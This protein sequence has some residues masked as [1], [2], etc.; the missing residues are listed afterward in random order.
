MPR[1]LSGVGATR[2]A[3]V[4]AAV[5]HAPGPDVGDPPPD[6]AVDADAE[7]RRFEAAR[8]A[9]R[10][11]IGRERERAAERLDDSEAAVFDAH[12]QFLED[13][14]V[15]EGVAARIDSGLP[16]EHA[17]DGAFAEFIERF[18]GLDGRNAERA[19]DLRDVRD[20]LLR[21]LVG[22]RRGDLA[23][24]PEGSVVLADRLTPSDT[25]RLDPGRVAG[26]ATVA[27][28]RTAHAA[29]FAR[30]LGLPA[31][32]GVG[33]ALREVAAGETVL[34]D[35]AG[36]EVVVDPGPATREAVGGDGEVEIRPGR[37][38]TADGTSVEV[39]ANVG[40]PDDLDAA[41]RHGA[42][43]VGLFR[44]ECLFFDRASPPD[45][46]E[47]YEVYRE[48]LSA[49][50]DGRVVVRT[51]DVGGD[52]PV[53]GDAPEEANPFLGERGIRRSLGPDADVFET[54]LRA[55]LRAAAGSGGR[56][57]VM[58]PMVSTVAEVVEAREV[59]ASVA[60]DLDAAGEAYALP[61]FGV[62]VE[63]PAAAL[64]A[65]EL[66][67]HV[68]FVSLGTNDLAQY[69]MAAARGNPRV[70]GLADPRHPAVL[71]AIHGVVA[72]AAGT[73]VR[74]GICGEMAGD[75][76]LTELLVGLGIRGLSVAPA[77]VPRVKRAVAGVRDEDAQ[78]LAE[79][80]LAADTRAAVEGLLDEPGS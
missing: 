10:G 30:S 51:L 14:Q 13:P 47:Q 70:A 35:G 31:V 38:T 57:A 34:V 61:A 65:E 59:L 52:K 22:E 20:R 73:D 18:E 29:I 68:E 11:A 16:A 17:V 67:D 1:R 36:G 48:A 3:G 62:M 43:G 54:Q 41:A 78:E 58:L 25:A 60:A 2:A 75:P 21:H 56:L 77:S 44:T 79:R 6:G 40:R 64:L 7:A 19:D 74:V 50:P 28:G 66:V 49:F 9:A 63:T 37:V 55:L 26:V 72:A 69:V 42:D 23:D 5:W 27:G 8:D 53:G 80:A 76:G 39:A 46:A 33:E 4:G 12:V 32:V 45:E 71:R 24:L 15:T